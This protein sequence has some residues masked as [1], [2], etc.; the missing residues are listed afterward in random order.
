MVENFI[1]E[2]TAMNGIN[3]SS[4]V[5]DLTSEDSPREV[6]DLTK[7]SPQPSRSKKVRTHNK[8]PYERPTSQLAK[9]TSE[10]CPIC[11]NQL[12]GRKIAVAACKHRFCAPCLLECIT[13]KEQ[14]GSSFFC[15]MCRHKPTQ[16]ELLNTKQFLEKFVIDLTETSKRKN[17][18]RHTPYTL[19]GDSVWRE[20]VSHM[21]DMPHLAEEYDHAAPSGASSLSGT[22]QPRLVYNSTG[23]T[24]VGRYHTTSSQRALHTPASTQSTLP[25]R[26]VT[27]Q[28]PVQSFMGRL[29]STI[30]SRLGLT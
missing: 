12:S 19:I 1:R 10:T 23:I 28:P 4:A 7:T 20:M 21:A 9:K 6:I 25:R 26:T 16:Q 15:P 29:F 8:T 30:A 3:K 5:I 24:S 2:H 17:T 13:T 11:L 18:I 27:Q 14:E 22:V